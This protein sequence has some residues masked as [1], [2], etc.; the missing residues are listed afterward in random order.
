M[1]TTPLHQVK[2]E[3]FKTLGHPM[4]IRVLEM[5]SECDRSVGEMLLELGVEASNLSQ[6]LAVLRRSG[7]VTARREGSSVFYSLASDQLA[8]L[9][10]V[11][12][13][14]L[15]TVLADQMDLL[16]DLQAEARPVT[17]GTDASTHGRAEAPQ[18]RTG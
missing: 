10:A 12:R 17:A 1:T 3:F 7:L 8:E 9:L 5:L 2:A 15:T 6:Q 16:S 11:A 4:R 14:I 18:S 13:S